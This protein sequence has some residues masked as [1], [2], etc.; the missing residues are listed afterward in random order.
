MPER[1]AS[2]APIDL[3]R[4]P[5]SVAPD[6]LGLLLVCGER[7]GRIVEV[8]AYGGRDDPASHA[9]RGPTPRAAIM[10]GEPGRLYVYRSYGIHWCAN[11]VAHDGTDA[12]A[13][14]VRA[15]EPVAGIEAMWADRPA[16]RRATDLASG[17]GR[18][19]QALG[20]VG[21]HGERTCSTRTARSASWPTTPR[22]RRRSRSGRGWASRR[23][24]GGRGGSAS[25]V[26][27]T[28]RRRA[29][30]AGW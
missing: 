21:A 5:E 4:A 23:L 3:A 30:P 6:L 15:V 9:A 28:G 13:V 26:T 12:G 25:P 10:F 8:E 17:P 7:S 19:C 11:V 16:A 1:T 29:E 24:E 18:L 22:H 20:I 2:F 14:L 27:R